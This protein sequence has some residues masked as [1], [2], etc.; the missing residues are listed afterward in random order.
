MSSKAFAPRG[1]MVALSVPRPVAAPPP[2]RVPSPVPAPR[3]APVSRST[4][5]LVQAFRGSASSPQSNALFQR[6][7]QPPPRASAPAAP[8]QKP[9]PVE[10]EAGNTGIQSLGDQVRSFYSAEPVN[11]AQSA[12]D[13]PSQ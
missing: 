13:S 2:S 1:S 11:P 7:A 12:G 3:P 5:E 6:S 8:A 10:L 4:Q 9:E